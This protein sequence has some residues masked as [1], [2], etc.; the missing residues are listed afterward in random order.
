VGCLGY[1]DCAA[2]IMAQSSAEGLSFDRIVVPDGSGGMQAGLVAGFVA[3]GLNPSVVAG[4]TVYGNA[5]QAHSVTLDKANQTV[6]LI[7]ANLASGV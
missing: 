3:P 2:E 5:G 4:F 1:A 6:Q 7:D